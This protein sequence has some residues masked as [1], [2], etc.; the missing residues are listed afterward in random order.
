MSLNQS[1][2]KLLNT[3]DEI[4]EFVTHFDPDSNDSNDDES[5]DE[6]QTNIVTEKEPNDNN[7]NT[8]SQSS[9]QIN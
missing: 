4:I 5:K 3:I 7:T 1:N 6:Q 2:S 8:N 9:V